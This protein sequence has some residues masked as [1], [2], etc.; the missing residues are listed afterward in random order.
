MACGIRIAGVNAGDF[1]ACGVIGAK[2]LA[3]GTL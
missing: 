1:A 2:F 3:I